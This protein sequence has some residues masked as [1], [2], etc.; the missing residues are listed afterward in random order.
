M[1]KEIETVIQ[2]ISSKKSPGPES[3]TAEFCQ[4]FKELILVLLNV[5]QKLKREYF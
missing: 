4:T 5:F 3:F 1:S 2:N